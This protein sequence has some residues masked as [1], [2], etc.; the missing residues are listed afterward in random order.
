MNRHTITASARY[1]LG[2]ACVLVASLSAKARAYTFASPLSAGC[3]EEITL[4]AIDAEGWPSDAAPPFN[5]DNE[6]LILNELPFHVEGLD[7]DPWRLALVLGVRFNDLHGASASDLAALAAVHG[8]PSGQREHCLRAPSD[9]GADGDASAIA[10]CRN[11]ILE[12]AEIALG[13]AEE[14]DYETELVPVTLAFSGR[15]DVR[16]TRFAFHMGRATHALQDSFTHTFRSA[17]EQQRITHVLNFVDWANSER[18]DERTDGYR[19]ISELDDCEAATA[20]AVSR[21]AAA[22]QASRDLFRAFA[23]SEGGRAGRLARIGAV[24]DASLSYAPGCDVDNRWCNAGEIGEQA[25]CSVSAPRGSAAK[26]YSLLLIALFAIA[27]KLCLRRRHAPR[28]MHAVIVLVLMGMVSKARADDDNSLAES[29]IPSRRGRIGVIATVSASLDN[30][31]F[32]E[33]VGVRYQLLDNFELG[34]EIE[35]N[36]WYS[37]QTMSFVAGTVNV[38]ASGT[39]VWARFKRC[40]LRSTIYTGA[41]VLLFS[42]IAAPAGSIGPLIGA[43]LL[44]LSIRMTPNVHLIIDPADVSV[45]IPHLT[46]VPFMY[47]QYRFTI[48]A[49][50]NF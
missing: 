25:S 13:I 45:P 33:R 23:N 34:L 48:G 12:E 21:K 17:T 31:A 43:N 3:H 15:R 19:H 6:R 44:G 8:S 7:R 10:S 32:A 4:A 40:E 26:N 14:I 24:V 16:L 36:P 9:D 22:L 42:S 46:G 39:V 28:A 38:F 49:Q 50:W 29:E 27:W 41:S 2:L 30:G 20:E 5:T 47:R 11:Y 1:L 18:Y 35:H 37:L